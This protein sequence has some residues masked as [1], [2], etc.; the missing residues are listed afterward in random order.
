MFLLLAFFLLGALRIE[1]EEL[2]ASIVVRFIGYVDKQV[3]KD[4]LENRSESEKTFN[5][6]CED[7]ERGKKKYS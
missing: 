2:F 7:E 1:N 4:G 6:T 3:A 5:T